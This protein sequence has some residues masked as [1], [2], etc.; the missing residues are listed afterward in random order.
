MADIFLSYK[1]EDRETAQRVA[2]AL[3]QEGYSVWWDRVIPPG[4]SFGQVIS[5][6]LDE[7]ECVVVLWSRASVSSDWVLE[8]ASEGLRRR[9]LVPAKI[10]DVDIPLGFRRVQAADLR[11]W[12]GG[13]SHDQFALLLSA[14]R[15]ILQPEETEGDPNAERDGPTPPKVERSTVDRSLG[16]WITMA[17]VL[18]AILLFDVT[19]IFSACSRHDLVVLTAII[20]FPA[21]AALLL[22]SRGRKRFLWI[23]GPVVTFLVGFPY[24]H[25]YGTMSRSPIFGIER[26]TRC[27]VFS[28][29]ILMLLGI[30]AAAVAVDVIV[31]LRRGSRG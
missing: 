27:Q 12:K 16:D 31:Q 4:K 5:E 25:N 26:G 6:K 9:V 19:A 30:L 15:E 29:S 22:R 2:H 21:A 10:E 14:V 23:L 7:S 8:E 18:A 11:D 20:A 28:S 13:S 1:S 3:E 24:G 17:V